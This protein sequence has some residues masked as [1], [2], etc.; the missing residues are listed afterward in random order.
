METIFFFI[1]FYRPLKQC[2]SIFI[3]P[4][5]KR[6]VLPRQYEH[7][8]FDIQRRGRA[9]VVMEIYA[10]DSAVGI[11]PPA[12]AADMVFVSQALTST[13]EPMGR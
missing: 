10:W 3:A 9:F 6:L 1:Q 12:G 11:R 13:K 8:R 4:L 5:I 2:D 7:D